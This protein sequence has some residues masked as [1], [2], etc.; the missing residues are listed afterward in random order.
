MQKESQTLCARGCECDPVD[1]EA[2]ERVFVS[3]LMSVPAEERERV[4]ATMQALAGPV[5]SGEAAPPVKSRL[6]LRDVG[7]IFLVLQ[8]GLAGIVASVCWYCLIRL[9]SAVA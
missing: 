5:L 2:A 9:S 4:L 6:S 1:L 7:S 3:G 8:F